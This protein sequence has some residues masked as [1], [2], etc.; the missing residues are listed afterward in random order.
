[1]Y[2]G[3]WLALRRFL[4]NAWA[5]IWSHAWRAGEDF[6]HAIASHPVAVV[7]IGFAIGIPAVLVWSPVVA[8]V[9]PV[10]ALVGLF[11]WKWLR[12]RQRFGAVAI[13]EKSGQETAEGH[14][15]SN[16]PEMLG[17]PEWQIVYPRTGPGDWFTRNKF[18]D[19]TLQP[20]QWNLRFSFEHRDETG[21]FVI[22]FQGVIRKGHRPVTLAR[23]RWLRDSKGWNPGR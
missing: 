8:I 14:E 6:A 18:R 4:A 19:L 3:S 2:Y 5:E 17:S 21:D 15:R 16:Q 7:L 22:R 10:A 20:R 11:L 1:M 12:P 9:L 23:S 13:T